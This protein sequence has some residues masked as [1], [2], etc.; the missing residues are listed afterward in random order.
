MASIRHWGRFEKTTAFL[1]RAERLK[2]LV[3]ARLPILA[4]MGVDRLKEATPVDTG[5]TANSWGY[6]IR[7]DGH[8]VIVE[9]TNSNVKKDWAKVAILL[10]DGHGTRNG[11]YVAPRAYIDPAI[12]PIMDEIVDTLWKEV[13]AYVG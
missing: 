7:T 13:I 4:Q 1:E 2:E 12:Q 9:W 8:Q 3:A 5:L 10:N 11:G 6:N